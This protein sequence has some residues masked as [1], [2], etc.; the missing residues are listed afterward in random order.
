MA[1]GWGGRLPP[2]PR[3]QASSSPEGGGQQ[4][5]GGGDNDQQR[6]Q[7]QLPDWVAKRVSEAGQARVWV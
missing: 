4:F 1:C 5:S 2:R 6:E 7:P 3:A